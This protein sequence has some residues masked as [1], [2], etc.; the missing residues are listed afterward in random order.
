MK[1]TRFSKIINDE[2]VKTIERPSRLLAILHRKTLFYYISSIKWKLHESWVIS[3]TEPV[4]A[5]RK[6]RNYEEYVAHQKSKL[7]LIDLFQYDH[8][9]KNILQGRLVGLD[10]LHQGA[11]VLCLGARIGTEVKSFLDIGCFAVGIDLNPGGQNKYVLFGDFHNI[12]FSSQ[13]VDLIYTNSLDHTADVGKLIKE[14]KRVLKPNGFL[15]VEAAKGSEEGG[16]PRSY[17]SFW[18][19]KVDSI[20]KLFESSG[21]KIIKRTQFDRPWEGEQLCFSL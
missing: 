2:I 5:K 17:E 12:Q 10:F 18:W 9:F 20:V 13:T 21:F 15:I 19:P 3:E 16:L 11:I 8:D 14:I 1:I 7:P 6:Y 4:F